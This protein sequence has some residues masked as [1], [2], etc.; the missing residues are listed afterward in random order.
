[1]GTLAGT[2]L[3]PLPYESTQSLLMRLGYL[4]AMGPLDFR[5]AGIT[6]VASCAMPALLSPFGRSRLR[7]LAGWQPDPREEWLFR[8]LAQ[9][10]VVAL[11]FRFCAKCCAHGYHSYLF[12]I[13][14]VETCPIHDEKLQTS[15]PCCGESLGPCRL[16]KALFTKPYHCASCKRTLGLLAPTP[17]AFLELRSKQDLIVSAFA[18][19][20]AWAKRVVAKRRILPELLQ[21]EFGRPLRYG[22]A[23]IQGSVLCAVEPSRYMQAKVPLTVLSWHSRGSHNIALAETCRESRIA[24]VYRGTLRILQRWILSCCKHSTPAACVGEYWTGARSLGNGN[25]DCQR[26]SR[27]EC[28]YMLLRYTVERHYI[29]RSVHSDVRTATPS[30]DFSL[31]D[32]SLRD[33]PRL[34]LRAIF[35]AMYAES[36]LRLHDRLV[37]SPSLEGV[38]SDAELVLCTGGSGETR[39][40]FVAFPRVPGM[41]TSPFHHANETV[42]GALFKVANQM[43]EEVRW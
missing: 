24:G 21:A 11:G 15:C 33:H 29:D 9:A 5:A 43:H 4:N 34:P 41:P 3:L 7:Q 31:T 37:F 14:T 25:L 16:S 22:L 42:D 1:M 17:L 40:G 27:E 19:H 12:Q 36:Y 6:V 2:D 23:A 10:R 20:W 32:R 30:Q 8:Q 18:P 38:R 13:L 35:L 28:A 26:F 39:W